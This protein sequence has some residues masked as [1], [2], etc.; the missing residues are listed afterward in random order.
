MGQPAVDAKPRSS[1][2]RRLLVRRCV[3]LCA[4]VA[5]HP[6][7]AAAPAATFA[8]D[9]I[10]TVS[11]KNPGVVRVRWELSGSEE[12]SELRLRFSPDRLKQFQA[13]GTL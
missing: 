10:V 1:F 13:S 2:T 12:V 5:A 4:C 8:I 3:V 11:Q 6:A 9:Y 7:A